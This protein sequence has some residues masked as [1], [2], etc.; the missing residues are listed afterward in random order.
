MIKNI[1]PFPNLQ[2]MEEKVRSLWILITVDLSDAT[3]RKKQRLLRIISMTGMKEM[4]WVDIISLQKET[5]E[6]TSSPMCRIG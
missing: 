2:D 5:P 1:N 6:C 3:S 4:I